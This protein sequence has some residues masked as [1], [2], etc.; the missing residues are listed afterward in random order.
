MQSLPQEPQRRLAI[1]LEARVEAASAR[2]GDRQLAPG[3]RH[4]LHAANVG[5]GG[6]R[7]PQREELPLPAP[8]AAT[9]VDREG[10]AR[11]REGPEAALHPRRTVGAGAPL[12]Q[13][14]RH[15]DRLAVAGTDHAV[16]LP[17]VVLLP[18]ASARDEALPS[19]RSVEQRDG[20]EAPCQQGVHEE[21]RL[22]AGGQQAGEVVVGRVEPAA[23]AD[24]Q[25]AVGALVEGA[26]A[27][28][29]PQVGVHGGPLVERNEPEGWE[30]NGQPVIRILALFG[31]EARESNDVPGSRQ[32]AHHGY[33][34]E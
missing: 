1:G 12:E 5:V 32:R 28:V 27:R 3:R 8:E 30:E 2:D 4:R 20:V 23:R 6:A 26:R 7:L 33:G 9:P 13:T 18:P 25:V 19:L 16:Q 10:R 17:Q 22:A 15:R 21:A 11:E 29:G 31:P 24:V 34:G 14:L